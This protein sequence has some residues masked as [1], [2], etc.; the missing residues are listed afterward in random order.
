M[1]SC[2]TLL[3]SSLSSGNWV[4]QPSRSPNISLWSIWTIRAIQFHLL[5]FASGSLKHTSVFWFSYLV[6][7]WYQHQHH[8]WAG[9]LC[10][11]AVTMARSTA[12]HQPLRRILFVLCLIFLFPHLPYN[13]ISWVN[14][15]V[16][17]RII[18]TTSY[19]KWNEILSIALNLM[20]G[21]RTAYLF[22]L[23]DFKS[24]S[25]LCQTLALLVF[26]SIVTHICQ[27]Y[28]SASVWI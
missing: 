11:S 24:T 23:V 3:L 13:I 1:N 9:C 21:N 27:K 28:Q 8:P 12:L 4:I 5:S 10:C 26:Q 14:Q 6:K 2:V 17:G 19:K 18:W 20:I 15:L 25:C 22:G 16:Q 7:S